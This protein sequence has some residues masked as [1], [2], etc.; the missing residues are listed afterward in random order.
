M[1]P[2]FPNDKEIIIIKQGRPD[3]CYLLASLDCIFNLGKEGRDLVK[4]RFTKNVDG[5]VTLRIRQTDLSA[6]LIPS[7]LIVKYTY[8]HDTL[9]NEDV[10]LISEDRL[11]EIDALE[12]G[13]QTNSLAVKILEHI[14][15]YYYSSDWVSS[16]PFADL[17]AHSF[18]ERFDKT[19][20]GFVAK[21]LGLGV[22]DSYDIDV[23]IKLKII[24]PEQPIYISMASCA[25]DLE[26]HSL[27]IKSIV[28]K[29]TG[30]YEFILVDPHDNLSETIFTFAEII[31]RNP[32]F[33]VFSLA[34]EAAERQHRKIDNAQK[35][36][37][38]YERKINSLVVDF[39]HLKS[40]SDIS[41]H[42]NSL[43]KQLQE[44]EI[45]I[46]A[47][48]EF[49]KALEVLQISY[50]DTK[51]AGLFS[52]KLK[53]IN[54]AWAHQHLKINKAATTLNK[55]VSTHDVIKHGL[56]PWGLFAG[57]PFSRA[58][59]EQDSLSQLITVAC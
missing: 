26:K 57:T 1:T 13:V 6:Y 10:F 4:S 56:E 37:R 19:S 27:R 21:L 46:R 53:E 33:C 23:I 34:K 12:Y 42:K 49:I 41:L 7:K 44:L 11:K 24:H 54:R 17:L 20:T 9:T 31:K 48:E 28:P 38:F 47:E 29:G 43:T 36:L 35:V 51:V 15:P 59:I 32:R 14:T 55:Y 39:A 2:L 40:F 8:T 3:D 45:I 5:S 52:D 22:Y 25:S 16:G 50:T 30:D 18:T 58:A